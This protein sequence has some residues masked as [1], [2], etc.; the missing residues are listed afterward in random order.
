MTQ[1]NALLSSPAPPRFALLLALSGTLPVLAGLAGLMLELQ[2]VTGP[3]IRSLAIYGAVI[4][5]FIGG[6][7]WGLAC[8][9]LSGA[10]LN[11]HLIY[12]VIPALLGWAVA[13][14]PLTIAFM[15]LALLFPA[16][17][18]LDLAARRDAI[19]PDWWMTMRLPPTI[20]MMAAYALLVF[21]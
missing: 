13:A 12:S 3:V 9:R 1:S 5:S 20:V 8:A 15:G 21:Y 7:H 6:A 19:V 4:V 11:R 16:V 18:V 17:L 14:Q 10:P 2:Q